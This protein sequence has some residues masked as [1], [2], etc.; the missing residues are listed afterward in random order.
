MPRWTG[1]HALASADETR[2]RLRT[3][4]VALPP[5]NR[6][7]RAERIVASGIGGTREIAAHRTLLEHYFITTAVRRAGPTL[8]KNLAWLL[9]GADEPSA[10]SSTTPRDMQFE[11]FVASVLAHGGVRGIRLGEPDLRIQAGDQ[12]IGVAVKR[13]TSARKMT[14]RVREAIRQIRRQD[15]TGLIVVN[16]DAYADSRG[17]AAPDE[18]SAKVLELRMLV[19]TLGAEDIVGGIVGFATLVTPSGIHS[20]ESRFTLAVQCDA[21]IIAPPGED[22][23]PTRDRLSQLGR[24][25]V[26]GVS[27]RVRALDARALQVSIRDAQI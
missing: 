14:T 4:G 2:G 16:L 13:L 3:L 7:D 15:M 20:P 11:L 8:T 19:R 5:G 26:R 10:D 23:G 1:A 24:N 12:E 27:E 6:L 21:Q 22:F 17:S 18:C 9:S 25:V